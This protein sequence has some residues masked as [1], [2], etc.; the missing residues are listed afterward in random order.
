MR[1]FPY[2][3]RVCSVPFPRP[4]VKLIRLSLSCYGNVACLS[5]DP[6]STVAT[7]LKETDVFLFF[8]SRCFPMSHLTTQ[9][10]DIYITGDL[11]L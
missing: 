7:R 3:H 10:L 11:D 8:L 6:R 9:D 2:K 4:P 1:I 5:Q